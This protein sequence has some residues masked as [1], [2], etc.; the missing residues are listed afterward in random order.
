[1]SMALQGLIRG[2]AG[3]VAEAAVA[4]NL[5]GLCRKKFNLKERIKRDAERETKNVER[6]KII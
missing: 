4:Y 6:K 2:D 1:M 3:G 5:T